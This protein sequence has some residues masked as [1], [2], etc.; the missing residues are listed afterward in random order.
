MVETKIHIEKCKQVK[1][2]P[3]PT[4]LM[5]LHAVI[6]SPFRNQTPAECVEVG[7][8]EEWMETYL[9]EGIG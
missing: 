1:F 2:P 6:S 3:P 5:T 4:S 7:S 9:D 8:G